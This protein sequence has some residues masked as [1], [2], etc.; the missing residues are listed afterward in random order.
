LNNARPVALPEKPAAPNGWNRERREIR[1]QER[2]NL[3]SEFISQEVTEETESERVMD[4]AFAN[5]RSIT[6]PAQGF[7]PLALFAPVQDQF[8]FS[9]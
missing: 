3:N 9:G 6:F 7:S 8:R 1:E 4:E 2:V 5:H